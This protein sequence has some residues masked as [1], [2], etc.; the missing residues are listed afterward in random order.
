MFNA[1]TEVGFTEEQAL[2]V[3]IAFLASTGGAS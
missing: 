3:T 1:L 2:T